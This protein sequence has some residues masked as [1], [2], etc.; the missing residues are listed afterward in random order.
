MRTFSRL[1]SRSPFAPLK[2]H[3]HNVADCVNKLRDLF[4][5]FKEG[6]QDQVEKISA[7]ISKLEHIADVTKNNIRSHL[8]KGLFMPVHRENLLEILSI[9]DSIADVAEDIARLL[10]LRKLDAID[11]FWEDFIAF[12]EGNMAAFE[13][14]QQIIYEI[15]ELLQSSFG[16]FEAEKVRSMV[17]EVA[18]ME[19]EV[20]IM[21]QKLFT[22][23]FS[24][25][26][27]MP[28]WTFYLWHHV[29]RGL[30][31]IS[32]YSEKLGYRVCMILDVK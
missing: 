32:N 24:L 25:A 29:F 17:N 14:A 7:E 9:Q 12:L 8:G 21:Q 2:A 10:T 19:H 4:Q 16:G 11:L 20:D 26:D 5:V 15:E 27:D 30:A 23:L 3:M 6:D 22:K 28:Y 1:F 31:Q 13:G 18:K